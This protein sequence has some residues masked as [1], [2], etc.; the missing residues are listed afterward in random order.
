MTFRCHEPI[1]CLEFLQVQQSHQ[2]AFETKFWTKQ[3][4]QR[5]DKIHCWA[6]KLCTGIVSVKV[7]SFLTLTKLEPLF[8]GSSSIYSGL[9]H[10]IRPLLTPIP[11]LVVFCCLNIYSGSIINSL[12]CYICIMNNIPEL[13]GP[14]SSCLKLCSHPTKASASA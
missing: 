14:A 5:E 8:A 6:L 11:Y 7:C 4:G 9:R 12:A 13:A 2:P 1:S 3:T 10:E